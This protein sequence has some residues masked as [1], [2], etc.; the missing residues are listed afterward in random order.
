MVQGI[1]HQDA[2][3]KNKL[4]NES[5]R[6]VVVARV[7]ASQMSHGGTGN[8]PPEFCG[9]KQICAMGIRPKQLLPSWEELIWLAA[10]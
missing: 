5:R 10:L 7:M 2:V 9:G 8:T 6:V 1:H 3:G 4:T